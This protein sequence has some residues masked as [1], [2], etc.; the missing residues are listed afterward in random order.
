[1]QVIDAHQHFWKY[2]PVRD[3]WIDDSMTTIRRDF[4]PTDLLPVLRSNDVDGCIVVQSDQSEAE[5]EF[6]LENAANNDFI[7]GVVGWVDLMSPKVE[8]RL[9]FYSQHKKMKGFRH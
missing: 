1:M 7:K 4:M 6:Q 9:E 3:A 2:N 5:N 8:E